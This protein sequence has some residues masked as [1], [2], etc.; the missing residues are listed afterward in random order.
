MAV[1]ETGLALNWPQNGDMRIRFIIQALIM[2]KHLCMPMHMASCSL[3][4]TSKCMHVCTVV[5]C[6][7]LN[8]ILGYSFPSNGLGAYYHNNR[9][10]RHKKV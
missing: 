2:G 3:K 10:V 8:G 4:Y 5:Q 7:W 9:I 1:L 6:V